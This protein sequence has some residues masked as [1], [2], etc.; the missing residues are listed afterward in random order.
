MERV[1]RAGLISIAFLAVSCSHFRTSTDHYR[2]VGDYK[3]P[4]DYSDSVARGPSQ[5]Q[6]ENLPP[7]QKRLGPYRPSG[8]FNMVWPVKS[9]HVN[10]GFAPSSDPD[11]QGIDFGGR[12]GEPILAAHEGL[13]I[14]VGNEFRGYGNMVLIEFDHE[15]ATLYAHLDSV[16]IQSGETVYPGEVIGRMGRTGQA[17]GVHLHFELIHHRQPVDPLPWLSRRNRF[18]ASEQ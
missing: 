4:S 2:G 1:L 11:H 17:S 3:V 13:V 15:W 9:V 18:A 16:D 10:R 14:Y 6:D 8:P 12:K 5:N 7:K